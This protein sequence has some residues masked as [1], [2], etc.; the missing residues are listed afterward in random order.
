MRMSFARSHHGLEVALLSELGYPLAATQQE[1]TPKQRYVLI[2][3]MRELKSKQKSAT[4][5][6]SAPSD[7]G[8]QRNISGPKRHQKKDTGTHVRSMI[9]A[10]K[11]ERQGG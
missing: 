4:S 11:R 2:A 6:S 5:S 9:E 7:R 3:A 10:R 1:L 8:G